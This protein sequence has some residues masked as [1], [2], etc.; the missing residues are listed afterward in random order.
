VFEVGQIVYSKAGR[1]KG[2]AFA[3][4]KSEGGYLYLADGKLRKIEKPKKKKIMHIQKTGDIQQEL[5]AMLLSGAA[6]D[7][8]IAS[9]IKKRETNK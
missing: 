5:K 8:D 4:V 2:R 9:Y 1:D 6:K 3:V 7:C